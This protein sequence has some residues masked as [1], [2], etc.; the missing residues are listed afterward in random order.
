MADTVVK[1]AVLKISADDGDTEAKLARI[2]A[3]ADELAREHPELKVRIDTAAASAKLA[4]LRNDLKRTG[5]DLADPFV[6]AQAAADKAAAAMERTGR[7][8]A[9]DAGSAGGNAGKSFMSRFGSW[10]VPGKFQLITTAVAVGL[11][12]LPALGAASGALAG[13]ALGAAILVGSK[14]SKGPL[15]DSF[16]DTLSGLVSMVRRDAMPLAAPVKQAFTQLGGFLRSLS[17]EVKAVFAALGPAVMPLTKGIEAL[18]S[19]LLPGFLALLRAAH[20]AVA[21]LASLLGNLGGDLGSMFRSFSTAIGP[22]SLILK[23][24]GEVLNGILPVVGSLA[25]TLARALG[26][27]F[28]ALGGAI[29]ALSPALGAIGKILGSLAGAVLNSLTGALTAIADLAKAAAPAFSILA[30]ALQKVFG[31]MENSGVFGILENSLEKVAKPLGTLIVALVRGLA[32]ILAAVLG[33]MSRLSGA[34]V[35][36]LASAILKL[37]PS[38]TRLVA[39]LSRMLSGLGPM[40]G[41]L[42]QLAVSLVNLGVALV[43]LIP[44]IVQIAADLAQL[45]ARYMPDVAK[46]A[47]VVVGAITRVI[48]IVT[49]VISWIVEI[50]AKILEWQQGMLHLVS[51]ARNTADGIAAAWDRIVAGAERM[52]NTVVGWFRTLAGKIHSAVGDFGSLLVSAGEALIDGLKNGITGALGGLLSTVESMGSKIVGTVK[53]FLHIGSPSRVFIAIGQQIV[54]GLAIGIGTSHA[55]V[56][57]AKTL[58]QQ[59]AAAYRSGEISGAKGTALSG[60][61]RQ[62]NASL[63]FLAA[64][65]KRILTEI[66]NARKYAASTEQSALQFASLGN[67]VS[68]L[69]QGQKLTGG[70]LL[71]GL[72]AELAKIR[73]FN[74]AIR[75]LARL[76]LDKA[77]LQQII[78]AG[79]DRGLQMAEAIL[80]GPANEIGRLDA[81]ER[82]IQ[83]ASAS[84]GVTAE[85][86]MYGAGR[87]AGRGLIR[88]LEAQASAIRR[89]M[90]RIAR[91]MVRTLKRELGISSPSTVAHYHGEMFAAGIASGIDAG[92]LRAVAAAQRLARSVAVAGAPRGAV[93]AGAG[94]Y[95]AG[96]TVRVEIDLRGA[97]TEFITWLKRV[98]RTR[99]GDPSVLGR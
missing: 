29:R 55:A 12:A 81:T 27:A 67:V 26:P 15:Y 5:R 43:P 52:V 79:P 64:A 60:F 9:Q 32:P 62:D 45:A 63:M 8:M 77:L 94:G 21:A 36:G 14:K 16:H 35:G 96:G 3:K 66:A 65:R 83:R 46:A 22:S 47:A 48:G 1:K 70:T 13:I 44:P 49:K 71:S 76:G 89:L 7:N 69:Q 11:S 18:V 51:S 93:L 88:G 84:L 17:P 56:T 58:A 99:G 90:E 24:L 53:S 28:A 85:N 2:Q 91:D 20:P 33:G 57:A 39:S 42:T 92:R 78:A 86:E 37:M 80:S 74:G 61:I 38:L 59:V 98:I 82:H 87:D 95:G 34:L 73:K 25:A 4:V 40:V 97:D 6:E 19:G 68:G 75:R 41:P 10:L 31:L 23:G 30:D 50:I 54:Q 72:H